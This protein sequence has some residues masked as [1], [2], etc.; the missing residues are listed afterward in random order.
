MPRKGSNLRIKVKDEGLRSG[1][2]RLLVEVIGDSKLFESS[3]T[4]AS[5]GT[6]PKLSDSLQGAVTSEVQSYFE[7]GNEMMN[8]VDKVVKENRQP[9][10]KVISNSE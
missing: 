3:D 8:L 4:F 2:R 10:G 7:R 5:R 6:I 1:K 9:A